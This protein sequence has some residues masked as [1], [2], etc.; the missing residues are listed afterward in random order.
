M[1]KTTKKTK[2]NIDK[3]TCSNSTTAGGDKGCVCN[4]VVTLV[5]IVTHTIVLK[6]YNQ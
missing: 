6:E 4:L 2:I 5:K 3:E 1:K